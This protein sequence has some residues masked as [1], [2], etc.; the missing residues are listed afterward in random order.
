MEL[1]IIFILTFLNFFLN[2]SKLRLFLSNE[3]VLN[4]IGELVPKSIAMNN[5]EKIALA[6]VPIIKYFTIATYPF[7]KL[8][9]FSTKLMLKIG[10]AQVHQNLFSFTDQTAKSL[11]TNSKDV[12]LVSSHDGKENIFN[13]LRE[14]VHSKF[15]AGDGSR[16][17]L[18][19]LTRLRENFSIRIKM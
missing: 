8:L 5:A 18:V 10:G 17:S 16:D 6:S 15:I 7:V 14:S 11:M 2:Y 3:I 4:M 12:E 9:S 1:A 13:Q 19:T